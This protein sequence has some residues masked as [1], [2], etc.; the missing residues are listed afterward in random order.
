MYVGNLLANWCVLSKYFYYLELKSAR[1]DLK[2][3]LMIK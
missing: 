2:K 1:P 3:L